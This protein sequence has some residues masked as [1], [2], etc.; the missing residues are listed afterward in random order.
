MARIAQ[1]DPIRVV[2]SVPDREY[3]GLLALTANEREETVDT[4]LR[5]P[6]GTLY[7]HQGQG[8]FA[9]NAMDP[10]TGTIAVRTRF[11]NP[12]GTLVPMT[13]V[14][15]LLQ[16]AGERRAPWVPSEGVMAGQR[17]DSVYVVN[18]E[19][20][21]EERPVTLGAEVH[22]YRIVK[23]GLAPGEQVV[24]QGLQKARPGQPVQATA[25]PTGP[26]GI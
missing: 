4:R 7:P 6:G 14:T 21:V 8:S 15:V 26:E 16:R 20:V 1:I 22:G 2:Y 11:D 9:D 19:G 18:A 25:A 5:L 3:M 17:G 23:E 13:H 12:D 10:A 24:V